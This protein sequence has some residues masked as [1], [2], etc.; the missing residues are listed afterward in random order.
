MDI[1]GVALEE[2]ANATALRISDEWHSDCI[3]AKTL[4]NKSLTLAFINTPEA[5]L[6]LIGTEIIEETYFESLD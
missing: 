5:L 1:N 4:L 3:E 2:W 6:P